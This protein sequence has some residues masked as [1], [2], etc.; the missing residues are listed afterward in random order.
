MEEGGYV[1]LL[2]CQHFTSLPSRLFLILIHFDN[3][4]FRSVKYTP[5]PE[6]LLSWAIDVM[7]KS[8]DLDESHKNNILNV[9]LFGSRAIATDKPDSDFDLIALVEGN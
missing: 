5:V 8:S 7:Q 4:Y 3:I 6:G 1:L 2:F 9:Y